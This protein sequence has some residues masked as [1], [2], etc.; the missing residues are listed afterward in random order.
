MSASTLV[1]TATD[2]I[3]TASSP[4]ET[5]SPGTLTLTASAGDGLFLDSNTAL[6]V[7]SATAGN[8]DL[9]ISAAGNLTLQ[10]NVS[11][12]NV[13][14]TATAGTLAATAGTLAATAGTLTITAE[15]IGSTADVIQ[16]NATTLNAT[17]NYGGIY[18]SNNNSNPLTLT[19]AAVGTASGLTTN[20]I[21]IY[22]AGNI[23][24]LP[25]TTT[26]TQLAT[27]VP[28]AVFSPGGELTL[29]A[30]ETLTPMVSCDCQ[31]TVRPRSPAPMRTDTGPVLRRLDRQL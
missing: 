17:A 25:Q 7:N 16:T 21:E 9:S 11:G 14:L 6:T 20:N 4:L 3:G 29:F 18:L 1:L 23:D 19:A 5:S 30:G 27:S 24:L 22:S 26:L 2:G 8:G 13:T 31:T 28:V 10:G 15:Q 12:P